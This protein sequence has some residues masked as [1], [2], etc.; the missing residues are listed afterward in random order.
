MPSFIVTG[1]S[2]NDYWLVDGNRD[3][4]FLPANTITG[5][6]IDLPIRLHLGNIAYGQIHMQKHLYQFK[7]RRKRSVPEL[8][9]YKLGQGAEIYNTETDVKLKFKF[10]LYPNAL[11]FMEKRYLYLTGGKREDYLSLVSF[12]P[13]NSNRSEGKPIGRY[14]S[15]NQRLTLAK[16]KAAEEAMV[17]TESTPLDNLTPVK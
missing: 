15:H 1:S 6:T 12:Y 9:Y 14:G 8:I 7:D 17:T 11:V 16:V 10:G 4:S 5:W 13:P 2:K 3:F